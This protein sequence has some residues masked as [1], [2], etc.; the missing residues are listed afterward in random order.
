VPTRTVRVRW[1]TSDGAATAPGDYAA[2][3]GTLVIP[4]GHDSAEL[5]VPV[6]GDTRHEPDEDFHVVLSDPSAAAVAGTTATATIV[7]DDPAP[8]PV[9]KPPKPTPHPATPAATHP[10]ARPAPCVD[11]LA[12]RSS[13]RRAKRSVRIRHR[14]LLARGTALDLGCGSVKRVAVA[15]GRRQPGSRRKCRF[16]KRNGRLG[17][18]VRC[19]RPRYIQA[20]GAAHWRLRLRLRARLPRGRYT[21]QARAIDAAGNREW[22]LRRRGRRSRNALTLRVR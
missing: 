13:F 21:V 2:A 12:P 17:K 16:L 8:P 4:H 1:A 6:H 18:V 20:R 3:G 22:K 7:D 15:I 11:R 14:R 9:A 5:T 10:T 19:R